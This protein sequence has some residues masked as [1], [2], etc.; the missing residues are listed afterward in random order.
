MNIDE[1]TLGQ[2]KQLQTLFGNKQE[3]IGNKQEEIHPDIGKKVIIRTYSAGAHFGTLVYKN[4]KEC[5]L[6]NAR[7]IWYWDGASSLSELA[8]RGT[9]KPGKCKFPCAVDSIT[10]EWIEIIP[11]TNKAI[12]SIE[13]VEEWTQQ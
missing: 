11:C 9:T 3:E 6:E 4:G 5:R 13:G 8:Q 12:E 7:R 2:I 10:L 1:L